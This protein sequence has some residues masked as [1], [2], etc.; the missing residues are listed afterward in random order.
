M[1]LT[2]VIAA[3]SALT[4]PCGVTLYSDSKYVVDAINKGW[5]KNWVRLG[6]RKKDGEV[7]NPELWQEL[8]PLLEKHSVKFVWVKGHDEN[9]YNNRCDE[10]AVAE[11]QKHKP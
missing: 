3:L 5:L 6:W 4:E 9:E 11:S 2:G 7:K 1:E 10:L 8:L